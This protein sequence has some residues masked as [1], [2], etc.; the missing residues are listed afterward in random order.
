MYSQKAKDVQ[1]FVCVRIKCPLF[2]STGIAFHSL[3][4]VYVALVDGGHAAEVVV[5]PGTRIALHENSFCIRER[6][7]ESTRTD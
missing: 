3:H 7:A 2:Y 4:V 6:A 1:N 5:V